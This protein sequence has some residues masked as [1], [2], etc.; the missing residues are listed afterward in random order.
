MIVG[1]SNCVQLL[2]GLLTLARPPGSQLSARGTRL[3][4]ISKIGLAMPAWALKYL[5]TSFL[6]RRAARLSSAINLYSKSPLCA[7]ISNLKLSTSGETFLKRGCLWFGFCWEELLKDNWLATCHC[8]L[9]LFWLTSEVILGWI[10]TKNGNVECF[11]VF[12][13]W[14]KKCVFVWVCICRAACVRQKPIGK[15]SYCTSVSLVLKWLENTDTGPTPPAHTAT[16]ANICHGLL[17]KSFWKYSY[18][19][20]GSVLEWWLWKAHGK[21][22]VFSSDLWWEYWSE[23]ALCDLLCNRLGIDCLRSSL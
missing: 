23:I 15:K 5:F 13:V 22:S 14:G 1:S 16:Q 18:L 10:L 11:G 9:K 2:F 4:V 12:L 17:L 7:H 6:W 8:E 20:R 19:V 21:A 3:I